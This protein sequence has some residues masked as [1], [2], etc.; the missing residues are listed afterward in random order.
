LLFKDE[1]PQAKSG[2][3]WKGGLSTGGGRDAVCS[4]DQA[5]SRNVSLA[6][7]KLKVWVTVAKCNSF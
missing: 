3:F 5:I 4:H 1:I 7:K 6:T 2:H